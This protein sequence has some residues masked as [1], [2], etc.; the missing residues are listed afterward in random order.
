MLRLAN[1]RCRGLCILL[2]RRSLQ[3]KA[4]KLS[5][6]SLKTQLLQKGK[7]MESTDE[8]K[9]VFP[10]NKIFKPPL[11]LSTSSSS[12]LGPVFFNPNNAT[13]SLLFSSQ[14]LCSP[15]PLPLPQLSVT[16]FL[17]TSSPI[18]LSTSSS[19]AS[20]FG[21]QTP[22]HT[23]SDFPFNRLRLLRCPIYNSVLAF[24]PTGFNQDQ[25]GFLVIY[26]KE[27]GLVILGD[28]KNKLF[29]TNHRFNGQI[30]GILINPVEDENE[31][32]SANDTTVAVGSRS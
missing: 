1:R 16:R 15:L 31:D 11:L 20:Q 21:P 12:V 10:V 26:C 24:F 22:L 25:L 5:L 30:S 13:L 4:L 2:K 9:S 3:E 27:S 23:V 6:A 29:I 32:V 7:P 18:S 19:I 14:S 8:W 28:E 17:S